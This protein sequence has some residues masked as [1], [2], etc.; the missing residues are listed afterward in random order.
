MTDTAIAQAHCIVGRSDRLVHALV[1]AAMAAVFVASFC[2]IDRVRFRE[3]L[4]GQEGP[5]ALCLLRHLTGIPCPTCG[6]TRS[7]CCMSRGE[8][9]EAALFHPLGPVIYAMLA[10]VFV[11]SAGIALLGRTWLG[12]TARVLVWSVPVLGIVAVAIWVVRLWHLAASGAVAE[13]WQG[14]LL[15]KA[16]SML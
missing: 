1:A 6:M 15:A 13:A 8:F 3:P 16:L 9:A 2:S 4:A 12:R 10:V 11:R 7:F 14:S 5:V